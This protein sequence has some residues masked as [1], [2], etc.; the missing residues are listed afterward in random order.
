[1]YGHMMRT[2]LTLILLAVIGYGGWYAYE[3]FIVGDAAGAG[4]G[5]M[6]GFAMP[7]EG[8]TVQPERLA[9]V[10]TATGTVSADA[11]A[12]LKAEIAG[13]VEKIIACRRQAGRLVVEGDAIP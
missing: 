12:I 11:E 7:V 2:I 8:T 3:H 13:R 1:M 6:A 4:G 5:G 9:I 10:L